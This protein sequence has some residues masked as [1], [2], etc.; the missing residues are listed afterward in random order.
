[1]NAS[2]ETWQLGDQSVQVTHLEKVYWPQAGFSKGDLLDYY[3]QIAPVVL[4][5]LIPSCDLTLHSEMRENHHGTEPFFVLGEVAEGL[6]E[7]L[8]ELIEGPKDAIV[9]IFL[10][11]FLPEMFNGIDFWT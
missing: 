9:Q 3:R 7:N 4:P 6:A 2:S 11:Q 5:H 8:N 1:M 10:T